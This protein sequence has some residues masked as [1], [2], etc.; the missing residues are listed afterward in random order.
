MAKLGIIFIGLIFSFHVYAAS[1]MFMV[2]KGD[3][4]VTT[5]GKAP[6]PVKVGT[7]VNQGDLISTG[8]DSRA[9][10]VMSDRNIINIAPN[11]Q[12]KIE[13][14]VSNEKSKN[15]KLSLLEGKVR[16]NVE[17]K[18]D[19]DKNK[20]TIRTPT[21]VAGVR[22]TQFITS[23]NIESKK[24]EVITLQ[25]QVEFKNIVTGSASGTEKAVI[26]EKGEKSTVGPGGAAPEPPQRLSA[27][28]RKEADKETTIKKDKPVSATDSRPA[29]PPPPP[30]TAQPGT[31][32]S[33]P[34]LIDGAMQNKF[35]KT[36]VK[37]EPKPPSN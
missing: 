5:P 28:A 20:F 35:D 26:I 37:V 24:T 32:I 4:K 33:T 19:N 6:L 36:K 23:Y 8:N 16:N 27:E 7:K 13:E 18:Y 10:I 30:A 9:K 25:G 34:A 11:T 17:Q 14:Y 29:A 2:V 31:N 12:L 21:A 3:V 22:G 15:V 1:G